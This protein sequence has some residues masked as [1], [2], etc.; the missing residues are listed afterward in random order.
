MRMLAIAAAAALIGT[1]AIFASPAS[2][3]F[4]KTE[5]AIKYRQSA[6]TVMSNH[7]GRLR[8]MATGERPFDAAAAK[9]SAEV[10]QTMSRL[11]WDGFVPGS[12]GP[13]VKGDPWANAADFRQLQERL[14]GE[15]A[16]L[17]GAS[18]SADTLRQ[19]VGATGAACKACHDKYRNL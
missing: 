4:A 16:K 6:F 3:Q 14:Q 7:R 1:G 15:T 18:G 12:T 5:D 2:A 9:A 17:V 10:V 19:Q 11:P 13:G 8:A